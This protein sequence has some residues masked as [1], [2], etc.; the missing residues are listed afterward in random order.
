MVLP[1]GDVCNGTGHRRKQMSGRSQGVGADEPKGEKRPHFVALVPH[2]QA[3]CAVR[4]PG[5]PKPMLFAKSH[6]RGENNCAT[7]EPTRLPDLAGLSAPSASAEKKFQRHEGWRLRQ[8][9]SLRP[10]R[11]LN[12]AQ[13][14]YKAAHRIT[15]ALLSEPAFPIRYPR[16]FAFQSA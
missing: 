8:S 7:R 9:F 11:S 3:L 15:A 5:L 14:G 1:H 16:D 6:R 13:R 2:P 4:M 10:D 12:R